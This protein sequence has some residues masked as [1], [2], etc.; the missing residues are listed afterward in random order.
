MRIRTD[1]TVD[2]DCVLKATVQVCTAC[3]IVSLLTTCPNLNPPP[4]AQVAPF[5]MQDSRVKRESKMDTKLSKHACPTDS[6]LYNSTFP[7][8]VS[9]T[10]TTPECRS[11]HHGSCA[12]TAWS[13]LSVCSLYPPRASS[14][15]EMSQCFLLLL[16]S[17][18][19]LL[20]CSLLLL[21]ALAPC[22]HDPLTL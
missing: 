10:L 13:R 5:S 9:R 20:L 4:L 8:L 15:H 17:L 6:G 12:R 11:D 21:L 2:Q 1:T 7:S 18:V 14:V 16:C 19:L 22:C 3:M